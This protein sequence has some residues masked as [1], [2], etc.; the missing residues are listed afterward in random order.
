[1]S[2]HVQVHDIRKFTCNRAELRLVI[3][4]STLFG[5]LRD[6]PNGYPRAFI[7]QGSQRSVRFE[8]NY[9]KDPRSDDRVM[10]YVGGGWHVH[11]L[12]D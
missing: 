7:V 4:A 9:T 5:A 8:Y 1:M 12:N 10:V 11:V 3:E 2:P 6:N